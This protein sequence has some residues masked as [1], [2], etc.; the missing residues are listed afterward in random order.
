MRDGD[1]QKNT[2][3]KLPPRRFRDPQEQDGTAA[4]DFSEEGI[5]SR[6]LEMMKERS[7]RGGGDP[8]SLPCKPS[9]KDGEPVEGVEEEGKAAAGDSL[10]PG[11][12]G[13]CQ[14]EETAAKATPGL[15][16]PAPLPD[17]PG[18]LKEWFLLGWNYRGLSAGPVAVL[19]VVAVVAAWEIAGMLGRDGDKRKAAAS[20]E[21]AEAAKAAVTGGPADVPPAF[22]NSVDQALFS[23]SSDPKGSLKKL[24]ALE[25]ERPDVVPLTY[26]VAMA[27]VRAGDDALA[28]KKI[29]ETIAKNQRVSDALALQARLEVHHRKDESYVVL[30]ST[31]VRYES[32]LRKAILADSANP[33]PYLRLALFMWNQKRNGEALEYLG[34]AR[35]RLNPADSYMM[36]DICLALLKLED[37]PE[38]DLPAD[39]GAGGHDP[40]TLFASAYV[41]AR[42]NDFP[43]AAGILCECREVVPPTL[44][45]TVLSLPGFRKFSTRPELADLFKDR[46]GA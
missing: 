19:L 8:H 15:P 5:V 35:L 4:V 28:E 6:R 2:P 45:S 3:L 39:A 46:A 42:K 41:A 12:E 36:A 38:A 13:P 9:P 29:A 30:G 22:A 10:P 24:L 25:A 43:R 32:L 17:R 37:T 20:A 11:I 31:D 33:V 34:S 16:A 40:V 27:A 1:L 18:S 21:A 23:L 26:F 7:S 14:H 44:F